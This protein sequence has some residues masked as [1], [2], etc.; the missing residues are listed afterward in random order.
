MQASSKFSHATVPHCG[1][2]DLYDWVVSETAAP[3]IPDCKLMYDCFD[4][5]LEIGIAESLLV[6]GW[7]YDIKNNN[8]LDPSQAMEGILL[9]RAPETEKNQSPDEGIFSGK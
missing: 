3:L 5:N 2:G 6:L 9:V 4:W 7:S 8:I 1:K